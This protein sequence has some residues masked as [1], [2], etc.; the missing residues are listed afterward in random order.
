MWNIEEWARKWLEN[1]RH[2]GK[3][4]LEIK[5]QGSNCYVYHT[6]SRYDKTIKRGAK[7]QNI[8]GNSTKKRD[9]F[10]RGKINGL[11]PVREISPSMVIRCCYTR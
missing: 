4:C 10:Q 6:T 9:L 3:K 1:Q 7:Y 5:M 8:S 2:E 11:L